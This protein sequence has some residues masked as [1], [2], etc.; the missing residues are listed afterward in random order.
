M[1]AKGSCWSSSCVCRHAQHPRA[2][3]A[4]LQVAGSRADRFQAESG[5]QV[6]ADG[7]LSVLNYNGEPLVT[8]L[9]R[10]VGPMLISSQ[11]AHLQIT[12]RMQQV[13]S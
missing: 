4:V 12:F 6:D 7:S 2:C 11:A 3:G 8:A 13:V 10:S 9:C 1:S 5:G